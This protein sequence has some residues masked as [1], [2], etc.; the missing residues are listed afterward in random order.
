[1]RSPQHGAGAERSGSEQGA[2]QQEHNRTFLVQKRKKKM[3]LYLKLLDIWSL[4]Q[5]ASSGV[6]R[7]CTIL[8]QN[9]VPSLPAL[10]PNGLQAHT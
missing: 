9:A 6:A 3:K 5:A 7:E 4:F 10:V 8:G 2:V 1:M